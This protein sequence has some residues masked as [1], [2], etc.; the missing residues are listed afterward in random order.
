MPTPEGG[1]RGLTAGE[2]QMLQQIFKGS[3]NYSAVKIHNRKWVSWIQ[4]DD[5]TM[6]PDG[7]I[8][9]NKKTFQE[10]FDDPNIRQNQHTVIHHFIH[11]MVHV[12]QYQLGFSVKLQGLASAAGYGYKYSLDTKKKLSD[13]PMESQANIIADWAM[14][15]LYNRAAYYS[16]KEY[17][18]KTPHSRIDLEKVLAD[19]ILNP[20]DRKNLPIIEDP[21]CKAEPT[22]IQCLS[23]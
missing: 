8:Y 22:S 4:A 14:Y 20:A 19:F 16:G 2:V 6:A 18:E 3:I 10:D 21:K 7:E 23:R 11:E 15:V 5:V 9:F 12:W 17:G 1:Y 13:Y